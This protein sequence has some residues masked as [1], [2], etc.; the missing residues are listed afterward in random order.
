MWTIIGIIAYLVIRGAAAVSDAG[1]RS[2]AINSGSDVYSSKTGVRD[3]KTGK[4]C[5]T[6][7]NGK[8]TLW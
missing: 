2:S 6:D 8:K 7:V 4:K 3:V 5:W 1:S